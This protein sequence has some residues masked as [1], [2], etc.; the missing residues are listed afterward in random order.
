MSIQTLADL[1]HCAETGNNKFED[2]AT[3]GTF[4][5]GGRSQVFCF[6]VAAGTKKLP[7]SGPGTVATLKAAGSV[8]LTNSA[9][10]TVAT[11]TSSQTVTVTAVSRTSA[12][13][14]TWAAYSGNSSGITVTDTNGYTTQ[15]TAEGWLNE[16]ASNQRLVNVDLASAIL[17]AG[18]PMAAWAD[19]ASP[20]PGITLANS[21][22][23]GLRWNNNATQN[24]P[25]WFNVPLP[26]QGFDTSAMNVTVN[27]VASKTG[28]TVGDATTFTCTAFPL[29]VGALHDNGTDV[30]VAATSAMTGNATAK[31]VQEVTTSLTDLSGGTIPKVISLSVT[32]TSGTLGTDDV[33]IHR[34]YLTF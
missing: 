23:V 2:V 24:A 32:P 30:V 27:I 8:T 17:A 25:V 29:A 4:D 22:A 31:M 10:V 9:G 14:T 6:S 16:L 34:I 19:N 5:F 12:N 18:T 21:K 11:L 20:N 33:I 15:T 3:G 7:D 13:V 26:F 1:A 28:A